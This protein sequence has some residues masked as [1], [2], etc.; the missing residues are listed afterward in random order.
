MSSIIYKVFFKG[1]EHDEKKFSL[2]FKSL[3]SEKSIKIKGSVSELKKLCNENPN[4]VF[5]SNIEEIL[6]YEKSFSSRLDYVN[7]MI[8]LYTKIKDGAKEGILIG[9]TKDLEELILGL[10]PFNTQDAQNSPEEINEKLNNLISNPQN[11]ADICI[12]D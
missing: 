7:Y 6:K 10:W 2:S 11:Y 5:F 9:V 1:K 3:I 4:V 8:I 12:I